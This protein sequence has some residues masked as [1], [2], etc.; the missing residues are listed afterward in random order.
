MENQAP[1]KKPDQEPQILTI[2]DKIDRSTPNAQ[3]LKYMALGALLPV[4][5]YFVASLEIAYYVIGFLFALAVV[6][7]AGV[8]WGKNLFNKTLNNAQ[9]NWEED[10]KTTQKTSKKLVT[11]LLELRKNP[12]K[13]AQ[14]VV[15]EV[16]ETLQ[17]FSPIIKKGL[18]LGA[19]F[20]TRIWA[21]SSLMGVLAFAVSLAVCVATF[22]QVQL[23]DKQNAK[24][25]TQND[26]LKEQ[27]SLLVEQNHLFKDQNTKV[28]RQI[29]LMSDQ[30]ASIQKQLLQIDDQNRLIAQ[31]IQQGYTQ[32]QLVRQQ[33]KKI[34]AQTGLIQHQNQRLDQQTYLQ[35]ADRRSSLV[36]LFSNI[37]DAIDKELKDDYGKDS[38]RNLSPQLIGRIVALSTRLKPYN[39]LSGDT[40][41]K[42]PLSPERGQ[43]L[44]N[45]VE[46]QLD[47]VSYKLI[48]EKARFNNA[49]LSGSNLK[50]AYL[51]GADMRGADLSEVNL[52]GADMKGADLSEVNLI[53]ADMKG[54]DL[55]K[56]NLIGADMK[57]A[58]LPKVNLIGADL[59]GVDL[60]GANLMEGNLIG[61][62]LRG[63]NLIGANLIGADLSEANLKSTN[64]SETNL[65]LANLSDTK[66]P[67]TLLFTRLAKQ[68]VKGIQGLEKYYFIDSTPQYYSWDKEKKYPYYLIKSKEN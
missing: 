64:L 40:L 18:L 49:D 13:D 14:T 17:P 59:I 62:D 9:N 36:F 45:L 54:A 28:E 46:S 26:L 12:P 34:D 43:L 66:I 57:G 10:L 22:M 60:I 21:F 38:I 51:V 67:D 61:V 29:S 42:K 33:N 11:Q 31:Q 8:V 3:A 23:L 44:V 15:N 63:A 30:N 5:G 24:L 4:M 48:F 50:G 16:T 25:D 41:I 6:F 1:N 68:K 58:D 7:Y 53:G 56:V 2:A 35:E 19:A 27:D 39:Y 20:V 32:N 37:M 55:P 65:I 52:I 47:S